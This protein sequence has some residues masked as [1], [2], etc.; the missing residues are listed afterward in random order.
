MDITIDVNEITGPMHAQADMLLQHAKQYRESASEARSRGRWEADNIRKDAE[1]R[2]ANALRAAEQ[3][4]E[5]VERQATEAEAYAA[6]WEK[7]AA[8]EE[9]KAG[10]PSATETVT[11]APEVKA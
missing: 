10:L 7:L 5:D 2:I 11:D 9:A 3:Q 8:A 6:H 4:A 1:E